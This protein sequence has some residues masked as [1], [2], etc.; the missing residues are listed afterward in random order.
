MT[1]EEKLVNE[2]FEGFRIEEIEAKYYTC[3]IE[4]NRVRREF[5]YTYQAL[6]TTNTTLKDEL[7][8]EW[9]LSVLNV[10]SIVSDEFTDSW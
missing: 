10:T 3:L 2:F 6:N 5:N 4:Q 7:F 9:E 1:E 8:P